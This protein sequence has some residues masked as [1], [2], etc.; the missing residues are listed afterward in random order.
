MKYY[1]ARKC[2]E[3]PGAFANGIG[4]APRPV[5]E[6][7]GTQSY[8]LLSD[9]GMGKTTTMKMEAR[10]SNGYFVSARD[11]VCLPLQPAWKNGVLFIDGL[12]EVRAGQSDGRTALDQV[13]ARLVELG[14]PK[15]RI[16]CRTSSWFGSNDRE[17]LNR[18][19]P[20]SELRV[21]ALAPLSD[22]DIHMILREDYQIA[23]PRAFL[24]TLS[25]VGVSEL[26]SNP[27]NLKLFH[28]ASLGNSIPNGKCEL[29]KWVCSSLVTERNQEHLIANLDMP[30]DGC[31][32]S[33]AGYLSAL[34]VLTSSTGF[35]LYGQEHMGFLQLRCLPAEDMV[36]LRH[37]L[38]SRL[39]TAPLEGLAQ[40]LHRHIGEFLAARYVARQLQCGLPLN[41]VLTLI[42]GFDGKLMTEFYGFTA[43]LS[44][45]SQAS[46]RELVD[47]EP[48]VI[49]TLADI[50]G[51]GRS[52][53]RRLLAAVA[54]EAGA[55]P[56]RLEMVLNSTNLGGL[57]TPDMV[58]D[59]ID[60]LE[61]L[62]PT[63]E[64]GPE[65]L[66][67]AQVLRY[68]HKV[69]EADDLLL[70]IVRD[71][72]WREE[73]R[74]HALLAAASQMGRKTDGANEKLAELATQ[75]L[76][77]SVADASD[78]ILGFLLAQ[79]YPHTL[80]PKEVVRFLHV[81]QRWQGGLYFE[82]WAIRVL[83]RSSETQLAKILDA[84]VA[85]RRDMQSD[86]GQIE[87]TL[88]ELVL[89]YLAHYLE[90][91]KANCQPEQLY[92]WLRVSSL[93]R[94]ARTFE[95]GV[96]QSETRIREFLESRP[97]V[98]QALKQMCKLRAADASQPLGNPLS[99]LDT[100]A[101]GTE[102]A[103]LPVQPV[104]DQE[105]QQMD[106]FLQ[107]VHQAGR[108]GGHSESPFPYRVIAT[109]VPVTEDQPRTLTELG[110]EVLDQV[111]RNPKDVTTHVSGI[112]V[113]M[114][115]RLAAAFLGIGEEAIGNSPVGRLRHL[116]G[117]ASEA[118]AVVRRAFH[119][120]A[121]DMDT[122]GEQE[123]L[124]LIKQQELHLLALP[125]IAGLADVEKL[126]S[127]I[128]QWRNAAQQR[129]AIAMY[130]YAYSLLPQ[131]GMIHEPIGDRDQ[132]FTD[133]CIKQPELIADVYVRYVAVAWKSDSQMVAWFTT[134]TC[135]SGFEHIAKLITIPLLQKLS[136]RSKYIH[137]LQFLMYAALRIH[138]PEKLQGVIKTKLKAK[139][140]T[141]K[142]RVHWL[143]AGLFVAPEVYAQDMEEYVRGSQYRTYNLIRAINS[144]P[145]DGIQ[146]SNAAL[147][148]MVRLI[149]PYR[150]PGSS[151]GSSAFVYRKAQSLVS[152]AL[153]A[154][155]VWPTE[156]V[157]SALAALSTEPSLTS[158]RPEIL[159]AADHQGEILRAAT[160]QT[161]KVEKVHAVL[162]T[163]PPTSPGDLKA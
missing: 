61:S 10:D 69:P 54:R 52:E 107:A 44:E 29:L 119:R 27:L 89:I 31:L 55:S 115:H 141:V 94:G 101:L 6:Y 100:N 161:R 95:F 90:H 14:Q 140:M 66:V 87:K 117:N 37:V 53:K 8:V 122:P 72:S 132:W 97:D 152:S 103:E 124:C 163:G 77:G 116:L 26:V 12:D 57:A 68:G 16:S 78:Q 147:E 98:S 128:I 71:A 151:G 4:S 82:F 160:F 102:H 74:F 36:A 135:D 35:S 9:A 126:P 123:V 63:E 114:L 118:N 47:L 51:F 13:R 138:S 148:L 146:P 76:E 41:R 162:S 155:A 109:E 113:A 49:A 45:L 154:L 112:P 149:G 137:S 105:S 7:R 110:R 153:W 91:H 144:F 93:A 159:A 25:E 85:R 104:S 96:R 158:W 129:R 19:S 62:E 86:A 134:V 88:Q 67:L 11:F 80:K 24:D 30:G 79:L 131:G 73:V 65:A 60:L 23:D 133:L 145:R 15:F 83:A 42:A 22:Q 130:F 120:A 64:H 3:L 125:C 70:G 33:R 99:F 156:E 136:V 84:L 1:A 50:S 143:A 121:F 17:R 2:V 48:A 139:S 46:R 28:L 5:A 34:L 43:W 38:G 142:Q 18:V 127:G 157:R 40:P 21:I 106:A 150:S 32:L 58:P 59:I 92:D 39:F 81:P 111:K 108:I 56:S 20:D 75:I